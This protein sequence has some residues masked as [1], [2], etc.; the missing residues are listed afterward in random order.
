MH[1]RLHLYTSLLTWCDSIRFLD[2]IILYVLSCYFNIFLKHSNYLTFTRS[3][4]WLRKLIPTPWVLWFRS[5][6]SNRGSLFFT[7]LL[8]VL[9]LFFNS[10]NIS[11]AN[12]PLEHRAMRYLYSSNSSNAFLCRIFLIGLWSD[13]TASFLDLVVT[14][15]LFWIC[16]FICVFKLKVTC[17]IN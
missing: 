5:F 15:V 1:R 14:I 2:I 4:R 6:L 3:I 10:W 7:L 8:N 13:F 16:L 9:F 12:W 17:Y 11:K